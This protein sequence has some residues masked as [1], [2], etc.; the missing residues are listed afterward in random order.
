LK[1]YGFAQGFDHF[2]ALLANN[3]IPGTAVNAAALAWLAQRQTKQPLFLYLHYMDVHG[4]YEAP[5]DVLDPLIEAV[6]RQPNKHLLSADEAGRLG[7]LRVLPRA[8][9]DQARHERLAQYREYW[10]ARYAAGVRQADHAVAELREKLSSLGFWQNAYVIV[11][12][13]H[14]NRFAST[15]P[16]ITDTLCIISSCA[17]PSFC[18]GRVISP[19]AGG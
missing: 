15:E 7:Y 17:C 12:A 6:E 11:T 19:P 5:P 18:A 8:M 13:D 2:D 16:G 9:T 1:E 14:A 4:P 10:E 3:P